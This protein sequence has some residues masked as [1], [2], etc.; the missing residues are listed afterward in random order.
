MAASD[1]TALPEGVP[2]DRVDALYGLP[3]DEFTP[4]RDELASELRKEGLRK[5]AEWVKGL[6][7]PSAPAWVVNQLARTQ[8]GEA[9]ALV[10][11]GERLRAA[12]ERLLAGDGG[13]DDVRAAG[14]EESHALRQLLGRAE[15]L[16]DGAGHAPSRATVDKV[17]Q[18][19]QAAVLDEETGAA[20][21]AGRLTRE[22]RAA[23]LGP[24]DAAMTGQA[25]APRE[26]KSARTPPP[27]APKRGRKPPASD[28]TARKAERA[29][30][31]EALREAKAA[32]RERRNEVAEAKGEVRAARREAERAQKLLEEATRELERAEAEE[33]EAAALVAN[34]E[35]RLKRLS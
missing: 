2:E 5:Q 25:E 7:K 21:Q 24:F 1:P 3:L 30:A 4:R 12:H 20:F 22:R 11:A 28:A 13:A 8:R 34:A 6:R 18:T 15:G 26:P 19:L 32:H 33:S 31:R 23:G 29:D 9:K 35:D 10:A 14:A 17:A 27:K 16:I